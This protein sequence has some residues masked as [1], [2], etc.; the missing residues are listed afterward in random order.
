MTTRPDYIQCIA[1]THVVY[2]GQPWCGIAG[3]S[4]FSQN[5][6]HAAYAIKNES[7]LVPCPECLE[8]VRKQLTLP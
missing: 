4:V 8:A 3:R 2:L 7:R 1:H 5:L 6:D